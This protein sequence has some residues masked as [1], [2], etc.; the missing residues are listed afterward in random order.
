MSAT[1]LEKSNLSCFLFM[2]HCQS[3]NAPITDKNATNCS[4]CGALII[5]EEKFIENKADN[6]DVK[7]KNEDHFVAV[8]R[9]KY[10]KGLFHKLS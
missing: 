4:Y 10:E 6:L 8:A 1:C 7:S 9:Q 2:L 3:C 5:K